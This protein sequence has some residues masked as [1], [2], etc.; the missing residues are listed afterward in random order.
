MEKK[1]LS[2]FK[3]LKIILSKLIGTGDLPFKEQ[4]SK[5]AIDKAAKQFQK[6]SIERGEWVEECNIEK[7]IKN[8]RYRAGTFIRQEFGFSNFFKRGQ[9]YYYNKKD[10]ISLA[11]ELKNRNVDLGRYMEY[12]EDKG[13]F[14]KYLESANQNIKGKAKRKAFQLPYDLKDITTSPAKT[15]SAEVI[16]EDI[17]R[18]KEEFFQYN[19][20]DYIDV[21]KGNHAMMKFIYHYEKYLDPEL[22]KRCKRWCENF[23]Y[24]NH[25]LELVTKKKEVFV[26]VKEDDMIQL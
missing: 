13:K 9:T 16:R 14:N 22:K 12:L 5:E 24:A 23:N 21:Y 8:A 1:I 15:P 17:K 18:L 19:L 7:Y 2:E 26:P 10:L 20:S 3:E 11:A 6:L 4:F 25:A